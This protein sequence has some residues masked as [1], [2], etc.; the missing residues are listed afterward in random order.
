MSAEL[1]Q[2]GVRRKCAGNAPEMRRKCAEHCFLSGKSAT[3]EMRRMPPEIRR[4]PRRTT[5]NENYRTQGVQSAEEHCPR[6]DILGD[7]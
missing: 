1:E 6:S 5:Q 4:K 7:P 2:N 3:P